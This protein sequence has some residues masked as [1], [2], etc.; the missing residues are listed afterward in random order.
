MANLLS[1]QEREK[2]IA[3]YAEYG[4]YHRVAKEVGR[5]VNSVKKVINSNVEKLKN[6][7][8]TIDKC[9]PTIVTAEELILKKMERL[10]KIGEKA[11]DKIEQMVEN[12]IMY[13]V[14]ARDLV[15]IHKMQNDTFYQLKSI[16]LKQRD[17]EIK[18]KQFAL[19]TNAKED[20]TLE[21][22]TQFAQKFTTGVIDV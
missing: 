15:A 5:S 11:L 4:I 13:G 1:Q 7:Q 14:T 2:I 8:L 16:S 22:L 18:E 3:L 10:G 20:G 9:K 12:P 6:A 17:I 21:A 19:L